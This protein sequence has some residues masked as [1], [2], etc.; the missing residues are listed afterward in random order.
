M[1]T[2][3]GFINLGKTSSLNQRALKK[4]HEDIII[5]A[6]MNLELRTTDPLIQDKI[7]G[8]S[9]ERILYAKF[10]WVKE[11]VDNDVVNPNNPGPMP[12]DTFDSS[13]FP[14]CFGS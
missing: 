8:F 13:K 10:D 7:P 9:T 12:T 6:T 4:F 3:P 2:I 5:T 1:A 11:Q 14:I